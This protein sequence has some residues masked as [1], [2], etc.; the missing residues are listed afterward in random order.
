MN[1]Y[2]VT[3]TNW[4]MALRR[5]YVFGQSLS[6]LAVAAPNG[7]RVL[8][9]TLGARLDSVGQAQQVRE[10]ISTAVWRNLRHQRTIERVGKLLVEVTLGMTAKGAPT[11][12]TKRATP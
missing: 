11:V 5:P 8:G 2:D 1:W 7:F 6:V 3:P 9:K 12:D 10:I 4:V